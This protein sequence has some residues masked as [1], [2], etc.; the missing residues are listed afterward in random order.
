VAEARG[1]DPQARA[2]RLELLKGI[3]QLRI[4]EQVKELA[5]VLLAESAVPPKAQADALHIAVGT[6]QGVD[7]LLTWTWLRPPH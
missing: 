2:K 4:S 6:V 1:G 7:F 5:A 3:P